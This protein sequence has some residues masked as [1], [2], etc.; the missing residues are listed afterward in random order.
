MKKS[1]IFL[2][3]LILLPINIFAAQEAESIDRIT[4]GHNSTYKSGC[5]E[6]NSGLPPSNLCHKYTIEG[7]S[8]TC[9][10]ADNASPDYLNRVV[11]YTVDS[12][13]EFGLGLIAMANYAKING[14]SEE[15]QAQA[16]RIYTFKVSDRQR[17]GILSFASG[18]AL[19]GYTFGDDHIGMMAKAGACINGAEENKQKYCDSIGG[20]E[21]YL[22]TSSGDSSSSGS[23]SIK[24]TGQDD[25]KSGKNITIIAHVS[26]EKDEDDVRAV[27]SKN[28]SAS[29]YNC[30]VENITDDGFDVKVSGKIGNNSSVKVKINFPGTSGNSEDMITEIDVYTCE[31]SGLEC[32]TKEHDG[33][34]G[35]FQRF[36]KLIT[37]NTGG[38]SDSSKTITITL[39]TTCDDPDMSDS[40]KIKNGCC[41]VSDEYIKNLEEDSKEEDNY[42]KACGPIV[43]LENDCGVDTCDTEGNLKNYKAF[44]HSFIR[45]RSMKYIML[46]LDDEGMNSS[47]AKPYMQ[48]YINQYCGTFAT[49]KV[50]IYT[51]ATAASV[52]GQFFIFD[53]YKDSYGNTNSYF[54]QPYVV[55]RSKSTFFFDAKNWNKEYSTAVNREKGQFNT[56]QSA[57]KAVAPAYNAMKDA[58]NAWKNHE[59][60]KAVYD[61]NG[62]WLRNEIDDA[63]CEANYERAKDAYNHAIDDEKDQRSLYAGYVSNRTNL[64]YLR[65]DC[66][67]VWNTYDGN[68][69][70]TNDPKITFTY[71]Q[72]S[73]KYGKQTNKVDMVVSNSAVKYWPNV[74]SNSISST[75]YLGKNAFNLDRSTAQNPGIGT[76]HYL[77]VL[78]PKIMSRI[79]VSLA[80]ET[81]TTTGYEF[82]QSSIDGCGGGDMCK[83]YEY[84]DMSF[85]SKQASSNSQ[86]DPY[87]NIK[88]I[89]N[90]TISKLTFYRPPQ[91]TFA[92]MNTGQYD[93]I[94]F[95]SNAS[96]KNLNG[97][98]IGYVYNIELTS[99]KGQYTTKFSFENL[100]YSVLKNMFSEAVAKYLATHPEIDGV[101]STCN[102]CNMEMA[103]RRNC[104]E[105]E[106]GVNYEFVPQFYYRTISLS[107]VTPNEREEETNWTDSKGDAAKSLIEQGSGL[108]SLND[109]NSN[110]LALTS[111]L[112]NNKDNSNKTSTYLADSSGTSGKYD[113]YDDASRDYLEYEVT[114]SIKDLQ[115]IKK[116]TSRKYFSYSQMKMCSGTHLDTKDVDSEY[117]FKCNEDMKECE[118]SFVSAYFSD[119]TGRNKWKYYVN[120]KYC[121]G[122]IT[123]CIKN[124]EYVEDGKYP[125]P[126]F[127]KQ[128]LER[129]K[130]WP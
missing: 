59:C 30:T 97:L 74:T 73:E 47:G 70:L 75:D 84:H 115:T 50:D 68:F 89:S 28:C 71:D 9:I 79:G 21:K 90:E 43:H 87:L 32:L 10:D 91:D 49:E 92:L 6:S 14:V 45:G 116:N 103:F 46:D 11:R 105:C 12:S 44:N 37:G 83:V 17:G 16:F 36:I 57:V 56:W 24:K 126:L 7:E 109:S 38:S 67:E 5:S 96:M 112:D 41:N 1:K 25:S 98:E 13:D 8:A 60:I 129:Y 58:Y 81:G 95:E 3:I 29:G 19:M 114:L 108:A 85:I 120:G 2:L 111:T 66:K 76:M 39:P 35:L 106:D 51:P 113:I 65:D 54:R 48:S 40:E 99:Y 55:D 15:D 31:G 88:T 78:D 118:S 125:D 107:D 72:N 82:P 18:E 80:D 34:R 86:S 119:T 52:S 93:S 23:F 121:V 69:D 27:P 64:Q 62:S 104:G 102:Y 61:D 117:C 22:P 4:L 130:N 127:T 20:I 124:L 110:Y 94:T 42:I 122:N 63:T 128:F 101:G 123:S 100:G 26:I 33:R 77:K 53:S